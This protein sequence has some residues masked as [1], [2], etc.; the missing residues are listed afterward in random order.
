MITNYELLRDARKR[1][2][3]ALEKED[4]I[5]YNI[6]I[7][8]TID[9]LINDRQHVNLTSFDEVFAFLDGFETALEAC[10]RK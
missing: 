2:C 8:S 1:I 7:N 3:R 10:N 6:N 5:S 9:I 4:A